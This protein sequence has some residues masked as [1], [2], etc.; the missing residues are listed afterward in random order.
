MVVDGLFMN[1]LMTNSL[2]DDQHMRWLDVDVG[3]MLMNIGSG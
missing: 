2:V 3:L 1:G